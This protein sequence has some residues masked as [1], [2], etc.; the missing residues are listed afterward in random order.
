MNLERKAKMYRM[1]RVTY[2][3]VVFTVLM[4]LA[5]WFSTSTLRFKDSLTYSL[6][7]T[8]YRVR[9]ITANKTWGAPHL[10]VRSVYVDST[11]HQGHVIFLIEVRKS[12]LSQNSIMACTVGEHVSTT[13]KTRI[14]Y[15][16]GPLAGPFID[17][18]PSFTHAL[19]MVDCFGFP[20]VT[21]GSN[22]SLIFTNPS[23]FVLPAQSE[24][25]LM[26]QPQALE[27]NR[28]YSILCC[29]A[30]V[31]G[32]PP[33]L[34]DWLTYQ[35]V[36]GINHVYMIAT[37]GF[38]D[39]NKSYIRRAI[40]DGFLTIEVWQEYL[41]SNVDIRYHSQ[42]LAYQ[43]CI[44]RF[45]QLYD[46]VMMADQDDFFVPLVPNVTLRY[47][48]DGWC[49]NRGSC[50]FHW[51]EYNTGCVIKDGPVVDG[52]LTT[53]LVSSDYIELSQ[54]KC[55]HKLSAV[56]ELGIHKAREYVN[57]YGA[58]KVPK[59]VAYVAHLRRRSASYMKYC[60]RH[61]LAP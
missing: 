7:K 54:T 33:F 25:P 9:E 10:T 41:R 8:I 59:E 5:T 55:I 56:R 29:T 22:C 11:Q 53:L 48:I 18:K 49:I 37:D 19:A 30:V 13:L 15:T 42:L 52:N 43:D 61:V 47:Y 35:K 31:Y 57:G 1:Y 17:D 21:N 26:I 51:F 45:R 20:S 32:K 38:Q 12:I 3:V 23:G 16:N 40:S 44:Y 4:V 50:A 46:Y 39:L 34:K 24:R 36:I 2:A 60:N 28:P 14:L 6:S 58:V 27:E